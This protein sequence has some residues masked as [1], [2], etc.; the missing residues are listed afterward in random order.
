VSKKGLRLMLLLVVAAVLLAGFL[1]LF[2][3]NQEQQAQQQEEEDAEDAYGTEDGELLYSF[4]YEDMKT[5]SFTYQGTDYSFTKTEDTWSYDA[6][7]AFPV[8]QAYMEVKAAKLAEIY[9]D[10]EVQGSESSLADFGLEDPEVSVTLT[11]TD[12]ETYTFLMGDRNST[13]DAYY[14]YDVH[15]GKYYLRDGSFI[16]AFGD[17][18][19]L[20]DLAE[21]ESV[22]V[23]SSSE[24]THIYVNGT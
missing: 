22:P 20:Y 4:D 15:S 12:G 18:F 24:I 10:R 5:I 1:V 6:D 13:A 2:K 17:G 16:V 19:D 23:V 7:P 9:V 14:M 3:K 8:H 11:L 21:L